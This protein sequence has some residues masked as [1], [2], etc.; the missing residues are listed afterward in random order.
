[1]KHFS[2]RK[3]LCQVSR[4][5]FYPLYRYFLATF[6]WPLVHNNLCKTNAI[7]VMEQD[8]DYL[9]ILDECRYDTFCKIVDDD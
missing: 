3:I 8:W 1:M 6:I 9:I 2:F 7:K 5:D 4:G